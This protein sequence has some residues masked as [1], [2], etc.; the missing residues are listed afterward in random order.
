MKLLARPLRYF[1]VLILS[2]FSLSAEQILADNSSKA[3]Y[4]ET[5]RKGANGGLRKF[6]PEWYS[7]AASENFEFIRFHPDILK[8]DERDFLI[9][10]A[11]NF[12]SLNKNDLAVLKQHLDEAHKNNLKVVIVMFS[13]PG[14]RWSQ[15][16]HGADDL[17]LWTDEN[18]QKQA[19]QFWIELANELKDHPAVYGFNPLNEPHP[20]KLVN[21]DEDGP[22][23]ER[24]INDS[25][26]S[27]ADL[28][29]FN[30]RM[31]KAIRSVAPHMPIFLDG[32]LYA[33]ASGFKY[34]KPVQDKNVFYAFHNIAPWQY[35]AFRANK[36]R[37]SYP[38]KMPETWNG[39]G[40]AW[41]IEDLESRVA[42]VVEF[43]KKHK[44]PSNRIIASEFWS[45]R[46]VEG[47]SDYLKDAISIF[48]KHNWHWS[49]YSYRSDEWHGLDYELG[50]K[51]LGIK[52]WK[53]E[54]LGVDL[55]P[56]KMR[57]DT[58]MW[59]VFKKEFGTLEPEK[60]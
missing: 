9:G 33:D 31:V 41:K 44:I 23:F 52:Y 59:K 26:D 29:K 57:G 54:K 39:P 45:D 10:N 50:V 35:A 20:G 2:T 51:P 42:A 19:E 25:K 47:T 53:A 36:G 21:L 48:N 30:Q 11:D 46:R 38:Q 24:W 28:N 4:W 13:L 1:F 32:Y 56:Y 3:K 49:F 37:Y 8:P 58:E 14:S 12:Q 5:Q 27:L 15:N 22:G 43:S 17:R 40:Q 16:N 34:L 55:E 18:F 6:R 60:D 7:A